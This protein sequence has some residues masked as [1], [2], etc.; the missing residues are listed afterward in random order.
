LKLFGH[1]IAFFKIFDPFLF[2]TEVFY[3]DFSFFDV[4]PKVRSEGFFFFVGDFYKFGINVKDTSSTHQ[5]A[6]QYL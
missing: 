5:G 3:N 2:G 6:P 1:G 4:I